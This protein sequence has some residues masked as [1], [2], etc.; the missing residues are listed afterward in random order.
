MSAISAHTRAL[1]VARSLL[2]LLLCHWLGPFT[3]LSRDLCQRPSVVKDFRLST[4]DFRLSTFDF[5]LSTF[6][7]RLSN[8]SGTLPGVPP[9][10]YY[11]MISTLYNK[12]GLVWGQSVQLNPGSNSVTLDQRNATPQN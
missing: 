8:G 6:D 2:T 1:Q 4:F 3:S 11:L 5:R 12:Q 7:F 10:T 9:A